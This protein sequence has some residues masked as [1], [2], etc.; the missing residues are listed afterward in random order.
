MSS[1]PD[2]AR[3]PRWWR[4]VLLACGLI[5]AGTSSAAARGAVAKPTAS[6]SL[7]RVTVA[8][9]EP[10]TELEVNVI[11]GLLSVSAYAR[12]FREPYPP[13]SPGP[14]AALAGFVD[15]YNHALYV[16]RSGGIPG[17]LEANRNLGP[18][19]VPAA[20]LQEWVA[21]HILQTDVR[22]A[23][24]VLADGRYATVE[25]D[26]LGRVLSV[27]W[28][29]AQGPWLTSTISYEPGRTVARLPFGVERK[30]FYDRRGRVTRVLARGAGAH[31]RTDAVNGLLD[32]HATAR[33]IA[34]RIPVFG[35]AENAIDKSSRKSLGNVYLDEPTNDGYAIFGVNSLAAVRRVDRTIARVGLL[36]IA[37][38]IPEL[39][40]F[41]DY[42]RESRQ[43]YPLFKLLATCHVSTGIRLGGGVEVQI[44]RTITS[45]EVERL[46]SLIST[47]DDWVYI[48]YGDRTEC[49]IAL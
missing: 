10:K 3:R 33:R 42:K 13:G 40:S 11:N 22:H 49:A 19:Q 8:F 14:E 17:V 46:D 26:P 20:G 48:T 18:A 5:A 4:A 38:A 23:N 32:S 39:R 25:T 15:P 45:P 34:K 9:L 2:G 24:V 36:D 31:A 21:P 12:S 30:Y 6:S 43:L 41:I 47:I 44:S 35:S 16:F 29:T 27:H 37:Q 28:P 1:V 7:Q